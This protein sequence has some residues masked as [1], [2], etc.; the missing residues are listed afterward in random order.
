M[1]LDQ[2]AEDRPRI[3]AIGFGEGKNHIFFEQD[4]II[5]CQ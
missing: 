2:F 1:S 4:A 5:A 3:I